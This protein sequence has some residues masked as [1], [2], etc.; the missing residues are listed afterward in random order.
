MGLAASAAKPTSMPCFRQRPDSDIIRME[1]SPGGDEVSVGV[2][3]IRRDP[4]QFGDLGANR[5]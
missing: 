5:V 1:S 2:Q 4:E 3:L